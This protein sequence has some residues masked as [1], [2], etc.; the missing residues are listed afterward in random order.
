M[1]KSKFKFCQNQ[2]NSSGLYISVVVGVRDE[3][4]L[5]LL[6]SLI[7]SFALLSSP[8]VLFYGHCHF[9]QVAGSSVARLLQIGYAAVELIF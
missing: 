8:H 3:A 4:F 1:I 2:I 6:I 5:E 7:L 9:W